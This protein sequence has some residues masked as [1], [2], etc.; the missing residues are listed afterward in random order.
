MESKFHPCTTVFG[1]SS[2]TMKIKII[3]CMTVL[4]FSFKSMKTKNPTMYHGF[5]FTS[6]TSVFEVLGA[7]LGTFLVLF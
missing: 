2:K 4:S 5:W 3:L 7:I 6:K 1:F